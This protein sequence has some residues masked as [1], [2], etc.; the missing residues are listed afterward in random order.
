MY[1]RIEDG[2]SICE[3]EAEQGDGKSSVRRM[4]WEEGGTVG[5]KRRQRRK[6]MLGKSRCGYFR[7]FVRVRMWGKMSRKAQRHM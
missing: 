7:L 5:R 2:G 4:V 3:M 1:K 6:D